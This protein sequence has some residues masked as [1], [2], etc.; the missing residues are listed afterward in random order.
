[1]R[2]SSCQ[3]FDCGLFGRSMILPSSIWRGSLASSDAL[4][5]SSWRAFER[6]GSLASVVSPR[7]TVIRL[8]NDKPRPWAPGGLGPG[9]ETFSV[10]RTP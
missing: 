9:A 1:M 4:P 8:R 6:R 5:L 10:A 7:T 3:E 2:F